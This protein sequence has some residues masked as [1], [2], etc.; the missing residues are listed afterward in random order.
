MK[1]TDLTTSDRTI[2][3]LVAWQGLDFCR[4]AIEPSAKAFPI[5]IQRLKELVA[6]GYLEYD[7]E[8]R[9]YMATMRGIKLLDAKQIQ[10]TKRPKNYYSLPESERMVIDA[11]LGV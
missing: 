1:D 5:H 9:S 6:G 3:M 7:P 4:W 2:V 11:K 8:D 10:I